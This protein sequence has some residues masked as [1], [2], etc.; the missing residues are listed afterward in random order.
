M[1]ILL[2]CSRDN[3]G[4]AAKAAFRLLE[5]LRRREAQTLMLAGE[6]SSG[7]PGVVPLE[8]R[9][10][11]VLRKARNQYWM[12]QHALIDLCRSPIS[13]SWFS[14]PYPG[15]DLSQLPLVRDADIINLHWVSH[16][17]SVESIGSLIGTGT[18][19][20]WTLH[21]ENPFTGGCHYSGNCREFMDLCRECPQLEGDRFNVPA[22]VLANKLRHWRGRLHVVAPS[23][24]MADTARKSR[25]MGD[26]PIHV[27]PNSLDTRLYRPLPD[28]NE[29]ERL[30]I[31][32]DAA[33]ILFNAEVH[34]ELRKGFPQLLRALEHCM[35]D[36]AFR[37]KAAAG[38]IRLVTV[39]RN[40]K[41]DFNLGMPVHA[42]GYIRDEKEMARIFNACDLFVLPSLEDNL[43]NTV[44]EAMACAVPVVAFA[45]GG[46]PEM[47][48]DEKTGLLCPVGDSESL[49]RAMIL[50][51]DNPAMR[52]EMGREARR[53]VESCFRPEVQAAAYLELF[54]SLRSHRSS[55]A[56]T[57]TGPFRARLEDWTP[58]VD[59]AMLPILRIAG[60]KY[61]RRRMLLRLKHPQEKISAESLARK[62]KA[63]LL[64]VSD[65]PFNRL[66]YTVLRRAW[67]FFKKGDP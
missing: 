31:P 64:S 43:P 3:G 30:G 63:G 4:G 49:A 54:S 50:L 40:K 56:K 66:V 65:T 34:G 26:C 67:R 21:D 47:I 44:L 23:R 15:F 52:R 17:Q 6:S 9:E 5:A 13:N 41:S 28:N 7:H 60:N 11:P 62:V 19:V 46:V 29:R 27:I 57:W 51:I 18:P 35:T 32:S 42:L 2:A 14:L 1:N 22:T 53:V 39:G 59:P 45:A 25:V 37:R 61:F 8:V 33:C 55:E 58:Q 12:G 36:S 16:F 24:W 48:A 38:K 20:V 10:T